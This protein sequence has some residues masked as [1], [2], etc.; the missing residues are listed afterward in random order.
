MDRET[1]AE[2]FSAFGPVDVRRMFSG[3]GLYADEVCFGIYLRGEFYLKADDTT[4]PRFMAEGS[5]PFI[6]STRKK[7]VIVNSWWRMPARLYDEPEE[8][9]NWARQ[10]LAVAARIKLKKGSR[11][12]RTPRSRASAASAKPV[13]PRRRKTIAQQRS[14]LKTAKRAV[15]RKTA[16]RRKKPRRVR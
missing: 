6:Y 12:K 15:V 16:V 1:A 9:A 2:L 10:A 4:I 14:A 7:T 3:F 5:E 11:K 13:K 8:L